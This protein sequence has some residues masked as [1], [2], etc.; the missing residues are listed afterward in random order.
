MADQP[1]FARNAVALS[2]LVVAVCAVVVTIKVMST[3]PVPVK[4]QRVLDPA[5][6]ERQVIAEVVGLK[7][8]AG[9]QAVCPVSV[10]V[11]KGTKF[12]CRVNVGASTKTLEITILDDQG[13][14]SINRL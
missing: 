10:V 6:V 13:E 8:D 1:G 11:E 3:D 12:D 14:L 2:S 4:Q 7:P 5:A 9:A